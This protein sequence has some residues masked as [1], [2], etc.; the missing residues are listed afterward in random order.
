MEKYL[1]INIENFFFNLINRTLAFQILAVNPTEK[2]KA[3]N[4]PFTKKEARMRLE[5]IS[6]PVASH[7]FYN[8]CIS[9]K[10]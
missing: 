6:Q 1:A 9:I 7:C 10:S 8:N 3:K 4:N 5:G 2:T